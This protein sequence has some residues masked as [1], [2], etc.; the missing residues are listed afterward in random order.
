MLRQTIPTARRIF[1]ESHSLT[2]RMRWAY[3]QA[4]YVNPSATLDDL[5]EALTTLEE[6]AQTTRRV[7]GGAHPDAVRIAKS[8]REA[9]EALHARETPSGSA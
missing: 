2:L 5:N 9:R 3:A 8:L 7:L 6:T 1:G 4:L